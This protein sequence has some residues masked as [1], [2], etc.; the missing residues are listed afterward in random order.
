MDRLWKV[1]KLLCGLDGCG[2]GLLTP[3]RGIEQMSPVALME[4]VI[5]ISVAKYE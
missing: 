3:G 4:L 5:P 1:G 2:S